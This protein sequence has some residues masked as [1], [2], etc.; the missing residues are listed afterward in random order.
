[1]Y[2]LHILSKAG[3]F[4]LLSREEMMVPS[5]GSGARTLGSG[6]TVKVELMGF[7]DSLVWV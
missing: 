3:L 6:D 2:K 7:S 1:M 4:S 5:I